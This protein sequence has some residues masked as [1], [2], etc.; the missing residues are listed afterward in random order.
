MCSTT[1]STTG[2]I[3]DL[4]GPSLSVPPVKLLSR[5]SVARLCV[6]PNTVIENG[7]PSQ[8]MPGGQNITFLYMWM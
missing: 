1:T 8:D 2:E 5:F 4:A 6:L 7:Q 3:N